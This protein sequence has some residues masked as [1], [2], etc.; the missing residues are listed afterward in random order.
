M[1]GSIVSELSYAVSIVKDRPD[2]QVGLVFASDDA[3]STI[4]Q[5]NGLAEKAGLSVGDRIISVNGI[6]TSKKNGKEI[7]SLIRVSSGEIEIK[8]ETA[9]QSYRWRSIYSE[10][11]KDI[12]ILSEFLVYEL[13][14]LFYGMQHV[15]ITVNGT[16]VMGNEQRSYTPFEIKTMIEDNIETLSEQFSIFEDPTSIYQ[17]LDEL[18][19]KSG[20]GWRPYTIEHY[21]KKFQNDELVYLV[22]KDSVD[23]RIVLTFRGTE[24]D[25]QLGAVL[26]NWL[27]NTH[28][29]KKK[30]KVKD[31]LKGK[32]NRG[33]N[34]YLHSG[35][36]NLFA[37][38]TVD[39]T[40]NK[41][42]TKYDQIL[43][44]VKPL[45]EKHPDYKLYVTGHSLGGAL[46]TIC[47]FLLA[48]EPDITTPVTCVSYAS[49][50]VGDRN[51]LDAVQVLER[52]QKLRIMRVVND[53]DTIA[54]VPS[55][56]YAHVG[57]EIRLYR[58]EDKVPLISYPD[59]SK[60]FW[61]WFRVSWRN[62]MVASINLGM[63][64]RDA[65]KRLE[66]KAVQN[67]LVN[68]ELNDL[69]ADEEVV[70]YELDE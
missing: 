46:A 40:D 24:N 25:A 2:Q 56:G 49:P 9:A 11:G 3:S 17:R 51:F 34:V 64:H 13:A 63:D 41:N 7:A 1:S 59:L 19:L 23:K 12:V 44:V 37:K 33:N 52:E 67:F 60:G 4:A 27:W 50:R 21:D 69:Y 14:K 53:K 15:E 36:Y 18:I 48:C 30:V 61:A 68:Y 70:G 22:T 58:D 31:C 38:K 32:V 29:W 65:K 26:P 35:F 54:S 28:I 10:I 66:N 62:S 42:T 47:S 45:L 20:S 39:E 16:N 8:A 5:V 6:P 57:F 43:S 55:I